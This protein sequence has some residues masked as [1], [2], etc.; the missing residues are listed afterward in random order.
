VQDD[1]GNLA[2]IPFKLHRTQ[3]PQPPP[4][5]MVMAMCV[6]SVYVLDLNSFPGGIV[7]K[8]KVEHLILFLSLM[9]KFL[10]SMLII[11]Q[12]DDIQFDLYKNRVFLKG[13]V[14]FFLFLSVMIPIDVI[15]RVT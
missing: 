13:G 5:A 2:Y 8:S 10:S 14:G 11:I 15:L 4:S 7:F 12:T 9:E 1:P 6:V 3:E